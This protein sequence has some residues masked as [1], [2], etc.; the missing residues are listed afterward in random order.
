MLKTKKITTEM[1][2]TVLPFPYLVSI[3]CTGC[4]RRKSKLWRRMIVQDANPR[5]KCVVSIPVQLIRH[6]PGTVR[7]ARRCSMASDVRMEQLANAN[8]I[9]L[10]SIEPK[11]TP[12]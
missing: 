6:C 4:E 2:S 11:T 12:P 8:C 3:L 10:P 9:A 7:H 1:L 5:S